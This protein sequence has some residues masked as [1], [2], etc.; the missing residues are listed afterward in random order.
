MTS[1]H[2]QPSA[3]STIP[4]DDIKLL[5]VAGREIVCFELQA[6]YRFEDGTLSELD[7]IWIRESDVVAEC[8]S[9]VIDR[10][11]RRSHKWQ[12]VPESVWLHGRAVKPIPFMEAASFWTRQAQASG[13][14]WASLVVRE[15]ERLEELVYQV[16]HNI[17][18]AEDAQWSLTYRDFDGR[19]SSLSN[20][21]RS[22]AP[23]MYR[24]VPHHGAVPLPRDFSVLPQIETE[25]QP[26][27]I[28]NQRNIPPKE[29]QVFR[30]A[31]SG[32]AKAT[33]STMK[34]AAN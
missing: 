3:I 33:V 12:G 15:M 31:L 26:I 29:R 7:S 8:P 17:E 21:S 28:S 10:F 1:Q 25:K 16:F 23:V 34:P 5:L 19:P 32:T 18:V 20:G 4:D 14:H 30:H 6:D 24:P 11:L 22:L 2:S 13:D 27:A 9:S